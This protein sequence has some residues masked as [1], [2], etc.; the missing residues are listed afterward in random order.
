M[1]SFE[2]ATIFRSKSNYSI[3]REFLMNLIKKIFEKKIYGTEIVVVSGLPRSGTSLVMK[4]LEAGGIPPLTDNIR[5]PDIDNPKGYFEFER[6]KNIERGDV[7]W[8]ANA[9]GKAVKI[10][11]LILP[12]LPAKYNYRIIFMERNMFEIL[13]SQRKMLIRMGEN[14]D[15]ISDSE[16]MTLFNKHLSIV[17]AWLGKQANIQFITLNYNQLIQDPTSHIENLNAFLGGSLDVKKMREVIDPSLYRQ[18]IT[19]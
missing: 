11:A 17:K 16:M 18:R 6:V 1:D 8:L 12:N 13:A 9:Q 4:M 2:E 5:T 15:K 19:R 7:A 10:V 3:C 14:P